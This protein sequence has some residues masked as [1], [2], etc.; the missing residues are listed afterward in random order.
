MWSFSDFLNNAFLL[1]L[2]EYYEEGMDEQGMERRL[3]GAQ[4]DRFKCPQ[5]EFRGKWMFMIRKHQQVICYLL[6]P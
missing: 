5:C 3:S 2:G 1:H 4:E 6:Y